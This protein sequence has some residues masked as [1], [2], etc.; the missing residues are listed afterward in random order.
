MK[1]CPNCHH[2]VDDSV[3]FCTK[4]GAKLSDGTPAAD[5]G[6]PRLSQQHHSA[7]AQSER[8]GSAQSNPSASVHSKYPGSAQSNQSTSGQPGYSGPA[9]TNTGMPGY[10]QTGFQGVT[11]GGRSKGKSMSWLIWVLAGAIMIAGIAGGLWMMNRPVDQTGAGENTAS[12][13]EDVLTTAD[14]YFRKKDY[15]RAEEYYLQ[16]L[17]LD[18]K[19]KEPY[20]ELYRIYLV[21]QMPEK[22]DELLVR[23]E[24]N[25]PKK[26]YEEISSE[27]HQL[28]EEQTKG[29]ILSKLVYDD[30]YS[31]LDTAP[32]PVRDL[33]WVL[34]KN[35]QFGVYTPSG[36]WL[37]DQEYDQ[38]ALYGQYFDPDADSS[39]EHLLYFFLPSEESDLTGWSIA[40]DADGSLSK[41]SNG[42]GG[43]DA[44]VTLAADGTVEELQGWG[45]GKYV[46][47]RD[48]KKANRFGIGYMVTRGDGIQ[49][50]EY[51]LYFRDP[52]V[53]VGPYA[54]DERATSYSSV[55]YKDTE[56]LP[57]HVYTGY[58]YGLFYVNEKDG[59]KTVYSTQKA[60]L[61]GGLGGYD[62][63]EM[64]ADDVALGYK[65]DVFDVIRGDLSIDY[66]ADF[67]SGTGVSGGKAFVKQD[68][69][70][71]LI[72]LEDLKEYEKTLNDPDQAEL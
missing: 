39:W 56:R 68:G 1:K 38:G 18:P 21:R 41:G 6:N 49:S 54:A 65:G 43:A 26:D 44:E 63:V 28:Q 58:F 11:D 32:Q 27:L 8:A 29:N 30:A 53:L 52:N 2:M 37:M 42:F 64:I 57:S 66:S 22:A 33:G 7:P 60:G 15:V 16:A 19:Q 3:L 17:D 12:T 69:K 50:D 62:R 20:T 9:H 10:G 36:E 34:K 40:L 46:P 4:C 31:E 70:W 24:E 48:P 67:E 47:V 61:D 51:Y 5:T 59:T 23:A 72:S 71:A 25:L 35:G 13:Y 14:R 45:T 55:Y